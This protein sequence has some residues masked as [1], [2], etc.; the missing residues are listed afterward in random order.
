[1]ALSLIS[2]TLALEVSRECSATVAS[3]GQA[4]LGVPPPYS[5]CPE[6]TGS[7]DSDVAF[8]SPGEGF[9]NRTQE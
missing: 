1:M 9:P 7:R 6:G 4:A 5:L 8:F 2:V 3:P